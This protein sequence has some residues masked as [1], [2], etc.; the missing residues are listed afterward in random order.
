MINGAFGVRGKKQNKNKGANMQIAQNVDCG[1]E[2]LIHLECNTSSWI[3][4]YVKA[5]FMTSL[6]IFVRM[7]IQNAEKKNLHFPKYL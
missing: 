4:N 1:G 5:H 2:T 3:H 6:A 7:E